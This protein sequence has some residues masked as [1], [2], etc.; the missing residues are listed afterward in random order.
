MIKTYGLIQQL[1]DTILIFCH[2]DSKSQTFVFGN[3]M[4]DQKYMKNKQT[5][6]LMNSVVLQPDYVFMCI[7]F[8]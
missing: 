8:T 7:I 3:T 4:G 1:Q 2:I 5:W 6:I